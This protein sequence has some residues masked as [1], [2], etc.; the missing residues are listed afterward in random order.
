MVPKSCSFSAGGPA[1]TLIPPEIAK[2]R[3]AQFAVAHGVPNRPMAKPILDAPR[4]VA[5]VC[6]RV[7]AAVPQHVCVDLEREAGAL[8]N[9]LD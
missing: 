5:G 1:A 3:R 9:A 8:A 4:V 2:R 7:A 6:Q